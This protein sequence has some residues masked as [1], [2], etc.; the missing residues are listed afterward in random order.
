MIFMYHK[1]VRCFLMPKSR[2]L[3]LMYIYYVIDLVPTVSNLSSSSFFF[4]FFWAIF[5]AYT[6]HATPS[7]SLLVQGLGAALVFF[8]QLTVLHIQKKN[9]LLFDG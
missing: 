8:F 2:S 9:D 1:R 5:V 3:C 7:Y 4:F 6:P